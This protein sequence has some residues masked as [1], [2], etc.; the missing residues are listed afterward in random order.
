MHLISLLTDRMD[1]KNE[2]VFSWKSRKR[3]DTGLD[4]LRA[5]RMNM[6]VVGVFEAIWVVGMEERCCFDDG[7][8]R[9]WST[10]PMGRTGTI[11]KIKL[12]NHL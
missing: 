11:R 4:T 6:G 9:R 3:L 10:K 12:Y 1:S 7:H 8:L 5:L 2:V